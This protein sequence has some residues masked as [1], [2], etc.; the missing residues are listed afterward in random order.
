MD[1]RNSRWLFALSLVRDHWN[2]SL[3]DR[4]ALTQQVDTLWH[5]LAGDK[6]AVSEILERENET[7]RGRVKDFNMNDCEAYKAFEARGLASEH[8]WVLVSIARILAKQA[9]ETIDREAKRR[10]PLLF[11]W[12]NDNWANLEPGFAH[13][14]LRCDNMNGNGEPILDSEVRRIE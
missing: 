11:K 7:I 8:L 10:K 12:L 13:I 3:T 14:Q 6:P 2:T 4:D 1:E 9:G 5:H